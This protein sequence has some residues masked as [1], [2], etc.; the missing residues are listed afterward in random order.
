MHDTVTGAGL[1]PIIDLT[2]GYYVVANGAG[3][4]DFDLA[5]GGEIPETRPRPDT[6]RLGD[7]GRLD[8]FA[9]PVE[10]HLREELRAAK[11]DG[12]P[13]ETRGRVTKASERLRTNGETHEQLGP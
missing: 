5:V 13:C 2:L 3:G 4:F 8:I 9:G 10:T 6:D 7:L 12:G 11:L 1:R